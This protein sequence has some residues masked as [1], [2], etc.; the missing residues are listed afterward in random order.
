MKKLY[1]NLVEFLLKNKI[2]QQS[3]VEQTTVDKKN[4]KK[5]KDLFVGDDELMP[6]PKQ[7]PKH[8]DLNKKIQNA[9]QISQ[10][11][12]TTQ[13]KSQLTQN[14]KPNNY[15]G[16]EDYDSDEDNKGETE[17]D[18]EEEEDDEKNPT[19]L[20]KYTWLQKCIIIGDFNINYLLDVPT[21]D[22]V[23]KYMGAL[24]MLSLLGRPR[25]TTNA[26]TCIDYAFYS[27]NNIISPKVDSNYPDFNFAYLYESYFSH[28]KPILFALANVDT[29]K[30]KENAA[31]T[32]RDKSVPKTMNSELP[33]HT[34]TNRPKAII[35]RP[36]EKSESPHRPRSHV[37]PET[38][39]PRQAP[40][41]PPQP[42]Q[43]PIP[44]NN[45]TTLKK[46]I[47]NN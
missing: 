9:S 32:I 10:K 27:K 20:I 44:P 13:K 22:S 30:P 26:Q 16:N 37:P 21:R 33:K 15:R 24:E 2:I 39:V 40:S 3:G 47:F 18:D 4:T 11:S 19:D 23:R 14:D 35:N 5:E 45:Q 6:P 42:K 46:I 36:K 17:M 43:L 7:L 29:L 34:I 38:V 1:F 8:S 41:K 28:H 31:R 12:Q 25:P